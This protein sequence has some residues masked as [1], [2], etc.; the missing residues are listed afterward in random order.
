M[1][2]HGMRSILFCIVFLLVTAAVL[3]NG[4][5][6]ASGM[7]AAVSVCLDTMIPSLYA[8]MICSEI[9]I[10]S[11][12]AEHIAR[13]IRKPSRFIFGADGHILA[14]FLFSQAAG[15][16]VGTRMIYRIYVDHQLNRKQAS[17]LAGVCCGGGP[18]FLSA[19][20]AENARHGLYIFIAGTISNLL[21]F[22]V[23]CRLLS[24]KKLPA[25]NDHVMG[26]SGKSLVQAASSSG[27][28]LL[29]ICAMVIVFGGITGILEGFGADS[30]FPYN[31]YRIL[32]G[33]TEISRITGCFPYPLHQLPVLGAM[34]SFGGV[35]VLMQL[36]T[37]SEG[38]LDIKRIT[39]IRITAAFLTW[40]QL[41]ILQKLL[42][43]DDA[44]HAAVTDLQP[45]PV[46]ASSP[47]PSLLLVIMTV[48]LLRS[49]D[50]G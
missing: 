10:S 27:A 20:F 48:M 6:A 44:V 30:L 41:Y 35:C 39:I 34:L 42:P 38:R 7:R 21:I 46:S 13:I 37:V 12:I 18:A 16:P 14:I 24:I 45:L 17:W 26:S 9:Y 28:A 15:Y 8:M 4:A 11:G 36:N 33:F 49:A 19:L 31:I 3:L 50:K 40:L 2:R 32:L 23:M 47:V 29:K 5:A 1:E 22:T 43:A 25:Q